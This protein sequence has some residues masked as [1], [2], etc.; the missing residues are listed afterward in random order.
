MPLKK[1]ERRLDLFNI[2]F[3]QRLFRGKKT[4]LIVSEPLALHPIFL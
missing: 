1:A 2:E 4:P 3:T